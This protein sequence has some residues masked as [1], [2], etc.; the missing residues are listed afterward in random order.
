MYITDDGK[1]RIYAHFEEGRTSPYLG[2]GVNGT[3]TIDWGDSTT[4]TLTGTSLNTAVNIQHIYQAGDFVITLTPTSG[5]FSIFGTTNGTHLLKKETTPQTNTSRVYANTIKKVELGSNV[6]IGTYAFNFC[7]SLESIT[8]P[9]SLTSI[10]TYAFQQCYS[11]ES[12]AIPNSVTAI[13]INAFY[14]CY[15]LASVAIPSSVTIISNNAFDSCSALTSITIPNGATSIGNYVFSGCSAL[16]SI[17]IPSSVTSIGNYAIQYCYSL[18][19][20]SIPNSVTSIGTY[21]FRN[22]FSLVS[23]SIP[24]SVTSIG[25]YMF[26]N[27]YTLTSITIPSSVT[28][29]SANAFSS[30][31]GMAEYHF[32]RTTPP[33]LANTNAFT[34]IPSDCIIYVPY[35]EDHSILNAYKSASNW[36]TYASYMQEEPQ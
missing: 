31:Y 2:L 13:N 5:S 21:A 8:I 1:T 26:S 28:K 24:N 23:A 35:S 19:S 3:V 25:T 14:D 9:N 4:D 6:T 16:T 17:T 12:I 34:G 32:L 29:I 10:S 11:L 36:S 30:C 18:V 7:H 27:C 15:S 22:C 20:A 33:S